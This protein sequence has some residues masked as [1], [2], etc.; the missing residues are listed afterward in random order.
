MTTSNILEYLE[1][2]RK[3]GKAS[4]EII[5]ITFGQTTDEFIL[6]PGCGSEAIEVSRS[7]SCEDRPSLPCAD[8]IW[9]KKPGVLP[10]AKKAIYECIRKRSHPVRLSTI[11]EE[12]WPQGNGDPPADKSIRNT[13]ERASE[14]LQRLGV[15]W[16]IEQEQ[17][18]IGDGK[19][20]WVMLSK[21]PGVS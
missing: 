7:L 21:L 4:V 3:S 14:D 2:A 15:G 9:R 16:Y 12:V 10:W 8:D 6:D 17:R 19:E 5:R 13:I 1:F 18:G 11:R 20:V